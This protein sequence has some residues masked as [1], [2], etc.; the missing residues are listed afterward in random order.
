MPTRPWRLRTP[1][2]ELCFQIG[3]RD[4]GLLLLDRLGI[5]WNELSAFADPLAAYTPGSVEASA[6]ALTLA[7]QPLFE[8]TAAILAHPEVMN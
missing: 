1:G 4:V 8:K 3:D 6:D 5:S 2:G 7:R